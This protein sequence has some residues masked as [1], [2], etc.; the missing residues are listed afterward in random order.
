MPELLKIA[1]TLRATLV[2]AGACLFIS[3]SAWGSIDLLS[4][5]QQWVLQL[6][7]FAQRDNALE[8]KQ[9]L[10]EAGFEAVVVTLRDPNEQ[11]YRMI[12]GWA[13]DPEDFDSLRN[14]LEDV[15]GGR[16][17]V[18]KNPY[19]QQVTQAAVE[20]TGVV[21]D[22]PR[23]RYL[24]AQAGT[25]QPT[26]GESVGSTAGSAY[27]PGIFHTLQEQIDSIPGFTAGGMQIIPALGLSAGYDDNITR[28][29]RHE[30]ESEFYIISSA[31][32]VELPSDH[33]VL[34]LT[35]ATEV[36]RYT[37]SK[38]DDQE[39]WY[40]R[41]D[42]D[43]DPSTRQDF[44]LYGQYGEGTDERGTGR[45]QG[46]AGLTPIPLDDW[47]RVDFGGT[48]RYGAIGARGRLD[49]KARSSTLEYT[50]NR[51]QTDLLDRDWWNAGATFYW[52]VASKTSLLV[53]LLYTDIDYDLAGSDSEETSWMLGVTWD[54]TARTSGTVRY[55]N[56][57]KKFDN[58]EHAAYNGPTWAAS[59]V[60][61]PRTYSMLTLTTTR[62]TQ[63]PDGGADFVVRQ[64][65]LLAWTHDWATRFGTMVNVGYGEDDYRPDERT[66]E[67]FYWSI[68]AQYMFNQHF[69]LG[70][71]LQGYD[72]DSDEQEFSYKRNIFMLT[73][74]VSL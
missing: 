11:R 19:L 53:D 59:L 68:G 51:E 29:S 8:F 2:Y 41:T 63:E 55:G 54:A 25:S 60:W 13:D 1:K 46:D 22:Q 20:S 56:Q 5:E 47:K 17:S 43:W 31:I 21:F 24:M 38:I 62:R 32:R 12:G 28:A 70:A 3:S 61:R 37:D 27:N 74:E 44:H 9:V 6:G 7:Y 18:L 14:R 57:Q 40:L 33:S 73:L 49:L 42:W 35:A 4:E 16:G 15:T 30:V 69:R 23:T 58:P 39:P 50:N 67:I 45:R 48:W 36:I 52:R 66:D 10:T 72:R 64:D 26:G 34:A 65:I 71:S